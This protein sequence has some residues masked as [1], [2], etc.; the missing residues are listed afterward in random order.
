MRDDFLPQHLRDLPLAN[1][2]AMAPMALHRATER[3]LPTRLRP[4]A[5]VDR[6]RSGAVH[7]GPVTEGIQP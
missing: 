3:G 1:R 7:P 4:G 6:Q 2:L 5:K